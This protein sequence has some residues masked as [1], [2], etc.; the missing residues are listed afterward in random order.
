MEENL[1]LQFSNDYK[2]KNIKTILSCILYF[3]IILSLSLKHILNGKGK[4]FIIIGGILLICNI[5]EITNSIIEVYNIKKCAYIKGNYQ[6]LDVCNKK[7]AKY[8]SIN[9][10]EITSYSFDEEI[11][12]NNIILNGKNNKLNINLGKMDITDVHKL[13]KFLNML[14]IHEEGAVL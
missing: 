12:R 11:Q 10:E 4:W 1:V 6:K 5:I 2:K 3:F 7:L 9:I 14:D 8:E 13:K